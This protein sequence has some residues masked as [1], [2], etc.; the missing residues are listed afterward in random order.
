MFRGFSK[1]P[2]AEFRI[3]GNFADFANFAWDHDTK[4]SVFAHHRLLL[5]DRD[6]PPAV[7]HRR[8]FLFGGAECAILA[9]L[10]SGE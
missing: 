7:G 1:C 6:A 8:S 9:A 2:T 5:N 3:I 10:C 4:I